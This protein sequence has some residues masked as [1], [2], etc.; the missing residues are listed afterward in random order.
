MATGTT[1]TGAT[2]AGLGRFC[3]R[4]RRL[5]LLIWIIGVMAVAFAGFGYGAAPDN[6]FSGGDSQ[7]AKAQQL[8]ETHFPKEQGDR[9]T[10]ASPVRPSR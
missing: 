8:M 4:R 5:V 9:P 6:D 1:P 2:P 10:V 7:S 3:F